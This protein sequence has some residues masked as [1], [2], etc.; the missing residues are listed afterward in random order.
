MGFSNHLGKSRLSGFFR[1]LGNGISGGLASMGNA[2]A[3]FKILN[4]LIQWLTGS[5]YTD[6]NGDIVDGTIL[7]QSKNQGGYP[8]IASGY[9]LD[10]DGVNDKVQFSNID[11]TGDFEI[12]WIG[13]RTGVSYAIGQDASANNSIIVAAASITLTINGSSVIFTNTDGGGW[14]NYKIERVG[15]TVNLYKEGSLIDTDTLA[16]TLSLDNIGETNGTFYAF[17]F[18]FLIISEGVSTT[19]DLRMIEGVGSLVKDYSGN[20]NNGTISGATWLPNI[21]YGQQMAFAGHNITQNLVEYSNDLTQWPTIDNVSVANDGQLLNADIFTFNEDG[22]T[23]SGFRRVFG[24]ITSGATGTQT[25]SIRVKDNGRR[26]FFMSVYT[27]ASNFFG[28]VVDLQAQTV[29]QTENRV[30]SVTSTNFVD[31]G[32]GWYDIVMTGSGGGTPTS[33]RLALSDTGTPTISSFTN[34]TYT[35]STGTDGVFISAVQLNQGSISLP[36]LKTKDLAL[37]E[38]QFINLAGTTDDATTDIE[39]NTITDF[40]YDADRYKLPTT[41]VQVFNDTERVTLATRLVKSGDFKIKMQLLHTDANVDD[42]WIDDDPTTSYVLFVRNNQLFMRFNGSGD[43]TDFNLSFDWNDFDF[44]IVDVQIWRVGS[45]L[46]VFT[47]GQLRDVLTGASTN[48]LTITDFWNNA[49]ETQG[50]VGYP[51]SFEVVGVGKWTAANGWVDEIGIN[52]GTVNGSPTSE[53]VALTY[54][55]HATPKTGIGLDFDGVNDLVTLSSPIQLSDPD[56][57]SMSS[58]VYF[59]DDVTIDNLII[60]Q[61]NY[62]DAININMDVGAKRFEFRFNATT[63]ATTANSATPYED[64]WFH[65]AVVWERGVAATFYING[66]LL[67]VVPVASSSGVFKIDYIGALLTGSIAAVQVFEN[68]LL[69]P[70]QI[71]ELYQNPQLSVPTGLTKADLALD[72]RLDDANG[73]IAKDYSNNE[74]NG[75][76][77]G[78]T[79]IYGQQY[80]VKQLGLSNFNLYDYSP[81]TSVDYLK[82]N[83]L[84]TISG[85][86]DIIIEAGIFEG[87]NE[88]SAGTGASYWLGRSLLNGDYG[89]FTEWTNA[90]LYLNGGAIGFNGI[91]NINTYVNNP[92]TIR[93]IRTGSTIELFYNG[94]SQGTQTNSNDLPIGRIFG[95]GT[96]N[97]GWAGLAVSFEIVGVGKWT[98]PNGWVDEVGSNDAVYQNGTTTKSLIYGDTDDALTDIFGNAIVNPRLESEINFPYIYHDGLVTPHRDSMNKTDGVTFSFWT[99]YGYSGSGIDTLFNKGNFTNFS[100]EYSITVESNDFAV[101]IQ[102]GV[103]AFL[104]YA[105][106]LTG[107]H[108]HVVVMKNN[109]DVLWYIDGVLRKTD[110]STFGDLPTNTK[111]LQMGASE[112]TARIYTKPIGDPMYF[113]RALTADEALSIY[114]FQKAKYE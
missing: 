77:S 108:H 56:Y 38:N 2:I 31:L 97:R 12:E 111:N 41:S 13:R 62:N 113:N 4:G 16:G 54:A 68:V 17:D 102:N 34:I 89:L 37:S 40:V 80:P 61:D 44:G 100:D 64:Q 49:Q 92:L 9:A 50:L 27:T 7:D 110:T 114:N 101:R 18:C 112:S 26:Y 3:K 8:N 23:T 57:F 103:V 36:F 70:T 53:I 74:N 52:N 30:G 32:N 86:F 85:D 96:G 98:N 51:K 22:T 79:W 66:S 58:W 87:S 42:I 55:N 35:P 76:I 10:F 83:S 20:G 107:V 95:S 72:L 65:L 75:T 88:A 63:Y 84:I 81:V 104:G 43:Q 59:T 25:L 73:L 21:P 99:T 14:T 33:V 5:Y 47:N 45:D 11:L 15:L 46:L 67:E 6:S 24:G 106:A 93:L 69:T 1:H 105:P 91:T 28:I 19:L 78:A 48:D 71:A 94:V 29:T 82:L 90:Y 109:G 39:G 60:S